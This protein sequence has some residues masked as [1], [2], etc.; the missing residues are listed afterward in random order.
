MSLTYVTAAIDLHGGRHRYNVGRRASG[1][2]AKP[3]CGDDVGERS[4]E[5][6]AVEHA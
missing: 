3:G 1:S 2:R 6:G 4:G 5:G